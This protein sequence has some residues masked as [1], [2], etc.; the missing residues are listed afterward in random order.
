MTLST[1]FFVFTSAIIHLP[2]EWV[3]N[4]AQGADTTV[5]STSSATYNNTSN[6]IR[7]PSKF[8]YSLH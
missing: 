5:T 8:C 2:Y 1:G 3:Y 7:Y 4:T 6:I